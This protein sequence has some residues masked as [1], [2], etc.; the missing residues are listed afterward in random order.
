MLQGSTGWPAATGSIRPTAKSSAASTVARVEAGLLGERRALGVRLRQGRVPGE[1]GGNQT[2]TSLPD[3]PRAD[4]RDAV[5]SE[6]REV[7]TICGARQDMDGGRRPL[8]AWRG[9]SRW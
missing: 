5:P 9:P 7:V 1:G 8:T 3:A 4:L 6:A 2:P